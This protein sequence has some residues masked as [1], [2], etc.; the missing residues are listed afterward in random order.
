[1]ILKLWRRLHIFKFHYLFVLWLYL[2][3]VLELGIFFNPG[4]F[5]WGSLSNNYTMLV[6]CSD[7]TLCTE[8]FHWP[9][10]RD[11]L[12]PDGF[13]KVRPRCHEWYWNY[14]SGGVSPCQIIF[15][16]ILNV[17][18]FLPARSFFFF[19]RIPCKLFRLLGACSL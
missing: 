1:M 7:Y 6:L 11:I 5:Q 3:M 2:P 9:V 12:N 15:S 10:F 13:N 19:K 18:N 16:H 14:V 4:G 17:R 8:S